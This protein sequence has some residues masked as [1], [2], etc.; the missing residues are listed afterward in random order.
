[1]TLRGR[2]ITRRAAAGWLLAAA[3]LPAR[4]TEPCAPRLRV[5]ATTPELASLAGAVGG[6]LVQVRTLVPPEMDPESFE[7][8]VRDLAL[9]EGA[10]VVLRVGLGFDFWLDPLLG[11]AR[12]SHPRSQ[13]AVVD[14]SAGIPLLEVHGRDPFARDGHAHGIANP[15]YWL[16]PANA[17]TVTGTIA[18]ALAR[19]CPPAGEAI[20]QNRERFVA[21]LGERMAQ[22]RRRLAPCRGAA[23]LAYH[24]SWPYFARRFHL[25]VVG[26]V[27]PKEGVTPSAAHLAS[28]LSLARR[29]G[30]RAI[31]QTSSEPRKLSDAL[32]ERLDI[33]VVSLAPGVGSVAGTGDYASFMGTNVE[34]LARAL[35][36]AG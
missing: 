1:M 7:P 16:D 4:A 24:N 21:Q 32:A 34:A 6:A 11:R 20:L 27:E 17:V 13:E 3:R 26:F 28:L 30:V 33:P 18:A 31:L 15:H 5:A 9:L 35:G 29:T 12:R 2:R 23:V 19:S 25:N 14:L 22:W 8:G 36:S 10:S